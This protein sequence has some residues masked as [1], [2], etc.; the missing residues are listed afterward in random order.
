[1]SWD[2]DIQEARE[3][4]EEYLGAMPPPDGGVWVVTAIEECEWGWIVHWLNRH[5]AEGSRDSSD[6][7]AGGGPFLI[8]RQTGR[9]AMCG[10]AH[11]VGHYVTAWRNGELPDVPRPM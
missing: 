9:V 4:A 7:Y 8:D 6:M 10:S 3:L 5:A 1:M 2:L 11:P